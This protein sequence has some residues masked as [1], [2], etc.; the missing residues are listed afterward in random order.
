MYHC[1]KK[2]VFDQEAIEFSK[3]SKEAKEA[4][5]K[6]KEKTFG[7]GKPLDAKEP[8]NCRQKIFLS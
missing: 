5:E 3:L 1:L 6:Y 7:E 2:E 8:Y 4:S